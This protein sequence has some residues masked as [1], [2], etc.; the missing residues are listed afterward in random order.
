MNVCQIKALTF[1]FLVLS[2]TRS[3]LKFLVP[4]FF[5]DISMLNWFADETRRALL[6]WN[7]RLA[8]IEG[9]AQGLLYLHKHSRLRVIHRDLKASNILLDRDMN[10]K[11]SDFGLARIFST[12]NTEANTERIVGTYG[13]IAPEY[14]SEG[15]FSIKSDVFSFGVLTLEIAMWKKIIRFSSIWRLHQPSWTFSTARHAP[16]GW[17]LRRAAVSISSACAA[18]MPFMCVPW[19]ASCRSRSTRACWWGV[20]AAV[21]ASCV[22]GASPVMLTCKAARLVHGGGWLGFGCAHL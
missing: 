14:T 9:I 10:L 13:Y 21:E 8:I 3:L 1:L 16:P 7:T 12:N 2:L 15:L 19:R 22:G 18:R 11:I 6:N 4:K 20:L 17:L 5:S